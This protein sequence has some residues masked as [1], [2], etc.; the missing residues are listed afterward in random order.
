MIVDD[1]IRIRSVIKELM[2]NLVNEIYEC[3]DGESAVETYKS[4][5]PDMVLMDI[6]MTGM[7]GLEATRKIIK[8]HPEAKVIIVSNYDDEEYHLAA[9]TAG[10]IDFVDK[11]KL[12][13]LPQIVMKHI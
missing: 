11:R 8:F 12:I 10:A 1:N 6:K 5:R 7:N 3:S 9:K 2:V 13:F 4:K